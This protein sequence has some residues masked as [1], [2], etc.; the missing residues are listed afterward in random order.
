MPRILWTGGASLLAAVVASVA[1]TE[2][3]Q[4]RRSPADRRRRRASAPATAGTSGRCPS[5]AKPPGRSGCRPPG[6]VPPGYAP[7]LRSGTLTP[8]PRRSTRGCPP[9]TPEEK[10]RQRIDRQLEQAGWL[11]QDYA[12]MNISAG[13]VAVREFPLRT[14][15]ADYML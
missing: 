1:V 15:E 12:D 2:F 14:G 13:P 10:A 7:P 8:C 11:V 9:M 4:G 6:K 3:N 5:P